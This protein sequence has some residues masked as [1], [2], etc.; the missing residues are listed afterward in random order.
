MFNHRQE[1]LR[2]TSQFV[3]YLKNMHHRAHVEAYGSCF[4]IFEEQPPQR[5]FG[6]RALSETATPARERL[7][8]KPRFATTDAA[9]EDILLTWRASAVVTKALAT[10]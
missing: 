5:V 3:G 2:R 9:L 7:N 8:W 6:D 4:I 10:R 1:L